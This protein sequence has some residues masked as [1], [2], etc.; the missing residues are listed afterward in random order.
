MVWSIYRLWFMP[1]ASLR[2]WVLAA[3][4]VLVEVGGSGV[5]DFDFTAGILCS[6]E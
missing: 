1:H 5:G 2:A 6:A 4:S 3:Q